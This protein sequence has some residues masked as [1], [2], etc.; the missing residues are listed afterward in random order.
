MLWQDFRN[1]RPFN[2]DPN[3]AAVFAREYMS[4]GRFDFSEANQLISNFKKTVDRKGK[5]EWKYKERAIRQFAEELTNLLSGFDGTET[6]FLSH[7]PTSK[8]LD[9]PEYDNRF[10]ATLSRVE[11]NLDFIQCIAPITRTETVIAA[12]QS[13]GNRPTIEEHLRT[14]AWTGDRTLAGTLILVD[15]VIT[16][17]NS[18]SACQRLINTNA[19]RLGLAG[20]FWTKTV[21]ADV[22]DMFDVIDP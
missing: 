17:G 13:G 16:A 1:D 18:F 3:I 5:Y 15:D 10:E 7:V 19:P 20:V 6:I 14:L 12:H 8:H 21:W 9:D 11:S 2:L 22:A 4:H